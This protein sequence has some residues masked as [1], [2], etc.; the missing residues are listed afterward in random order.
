[1]YGTASQAGRGHDARRGWFTVQLGKEGSRKAC[2]QG[3]RDA[4]YRRASVRKEGRQA[5][6]AEGKGALLG[7]GGGL[8]KTRPFILVA[9]DCKEF[10]REGA[11]GG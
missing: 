10:V 4:L 11:E 7:V 2:R 8:I 5:G 1:M 6:R 9:V 3:C